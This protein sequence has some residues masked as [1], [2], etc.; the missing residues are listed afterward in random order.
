MKA[1]INGKVYDTTRAKYID[2]YTV[3]HSFSDKYEILEYLYRTPS[4]DYFT[5]LFGGERTKYADGV[6][7]PLSPS[8]ARAWADAH[9]DA[10]R[11][12]ELLPDLFKAAA[13][14]PAATA[15]VQLTITITPESVQQFLTLASLY[16]PALLGS[17]GQLVGHRIDDGNAGVAVI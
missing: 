5:G 15:G 4:G 8:E 11:R 14:Q 3:T 10:D 12:E 2:G 16:A 6:I 1:T 17:L 7:T 9:I 13:P